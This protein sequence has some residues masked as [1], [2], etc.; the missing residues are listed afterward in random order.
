[1]LFRSLSQPD[2]VHHLSEARAI[3]TVDSAAAHIATAL[4]K[5]ATIIVGGG[6]F[7]RFS[8]WGHGVRQNWRS[9]KLDC[10]DCDWTCRHTSVRC[11][12]DLP[13]EEVALGLNKML[14]H[15]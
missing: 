9:H 13:P 7:G 11:L 14:A 4:D 5:P 10:F 2:F 15:A 12:V 3:A 8:P 1:M 6:H